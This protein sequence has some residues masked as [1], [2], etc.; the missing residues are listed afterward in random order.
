M[1]F[2]GRK[3]LLLIASMTLFSHAYS[4]NSEG[5][6]GYLHQIDLYGPDTAAKSKEHSEPN[7]EIHKVEDSPIHDRIPII[8]AGGELTDDD[9][10]SLA[11]A[12]RQKAIAEQQKKKLEIDDLFSEARNYI[13]TPS[14]AETNLENELES[15]NH[16][17]TP[18]FR[19]TPSNFA[20]GAKE[21]GYEYSD[22]EFTFKPTNSEHADRWSEELT[23]RIKDGWSVD[24]NR[25]FQDNQGD[26]DSAVTRMQIRFK[27]KH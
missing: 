23:R 26:A 19:E 20:W 6:E 13:Q 21:N 10:H 14:P 2:N 24:L 11:E 8:E 12:I 22:Y 18:G 27:R 4:E 1:L 17:T 25:S 3:I 16:S 7:E 9:I 15:L 5:L